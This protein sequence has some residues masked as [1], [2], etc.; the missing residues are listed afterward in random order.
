[1]ATRAQVERLRTANQGIVARAEVDLGRFWN[2]LDPG[3]P[4]SAL[5]ALLDFLPLLV[6]RYGEIAALVA[7]EWYDELRAQ[8]GAGRRFGAI[9]GG[10]V[11]PNAVEKSAR[12]AAAALFAGDPAQTLSTLAGTMQRHVL[13]PGRDTVARSAQQDPGRPQWARVPS[14]TESCDFC[15]TLASRG[16]EY[17]SSRTAGE[18]NRFHDR[19]DCVPTPI[20]QGDSLPEGYDPDDLY[21]QYLARQ[22]AVA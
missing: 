19:C 10:L 3:R 14:G 18:G 16:A 17:G 8:S 9:P 2:Q 7:A 22:T 13:Q 20:W 21:Q 15:L 6:D 1:M 11:P 5:D 12:W 4:Q